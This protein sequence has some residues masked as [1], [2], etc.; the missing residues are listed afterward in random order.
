M[1]HNQKPAEKPRA[2][3][4]ADRASH[5]ANTQQGLATYQCENEADREKVRDLLEAAVKA[6]SAA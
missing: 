6:G 5:F 2:P 4:F 3:E 1:T